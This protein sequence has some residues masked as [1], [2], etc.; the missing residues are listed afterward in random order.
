M[1]PLV[2]QRLKACLEG[3]VGLIYPPACIACQAATG[4]PHT[5]C[6]AC[7]AGIRF[8][9]RPFCERLGTPFA[10]DLGIA[11]LSPAAIAEPPVF[12]RA[13][14]VA[15]YDGAASALVRH[16]KYGDRLDLARAMGAMMTRAGAE[17]LSQADVIVPVPLHRWRLWRRRFNQAMALADIV[18]RGSGVPCDPF[19]LA[20]VKPTRQQVG[21]TKAQR[22]TNLQGAF[23]VPEDAGARLMGRRVL[24]VDDVLTTGSTGNAAARALLR[25]GA[26]GVD[27]LTFASVVT[28]A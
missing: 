4:E 21:L 10:V 14:A 16:L 5:L 20:R 23:R 9:E 26:S 11:L 28:D 2:V 19:L 18:A 3:I 17:L 13:R 1:H 24:L 12:E 27:I 15:A 7:W 8:I 22:Q 25:G 6:A